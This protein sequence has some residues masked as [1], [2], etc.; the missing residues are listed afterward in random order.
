VISNSE[1]KQEVSIKSS[2]SFNPNLQKITETPEIL[3]FNKKH[4]LAIDVLLAF[5][6]SANQ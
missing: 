2:E 6:T 5:N 3:S 1:V 4:I